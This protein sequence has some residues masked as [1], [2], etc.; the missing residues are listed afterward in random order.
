MENLSLIIA[1]LISAYI[2]DYG[3]AVQIVSVVGTLRLFFKPIVAAIES[4]VAASE[5]KNDDI[6]LGKV[7][8]NS[9]YKAFIFVLDLVGSIKVPKKK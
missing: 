5:S 9:I 2:G 6:V 3:W 7:K 4:A 1:P 8:Q